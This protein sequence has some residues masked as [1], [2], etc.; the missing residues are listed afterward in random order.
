MK[1]LVTKENT[2]KFENGTSILK[3]FSVHHLKSD[4]LR[5]MSRANNVPIPEHLEETK[6][7]VVKTYNQLLDKRALRMAVEKS[8]SFEIQKLWRVIG[9]A[10]NKLLDDGWYSHVANV[11]C[12]TAMQ[13]TRLTKSINSIWFLSGKKCTEIVEVPIRS[14]SFRDIVEYEGSRYL[15][16]LGGFLCLQTF[17]FVGSANEH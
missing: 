2:T 4:V 1:S 3:T 12:Q 16:L 7:V 14:T 10:A 17:R 15:F 13:A 9:E 5:N 8:S 11:E 6:Q